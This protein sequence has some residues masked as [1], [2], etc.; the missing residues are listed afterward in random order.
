[1]NYSVYLQDNDKVF[2]FTLQMG[3]KRDGISI[4]P[5]NPGCKRKQP[6]FMFIP[7]PHPPNCSEGM[8]SIFGMEKISLFCFDW[9]F[10]EHEC[11]VC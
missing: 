8:P 3:E 9:L 7:A 4:D 5:F 11:N 6:F 10:M 1:M 2:A